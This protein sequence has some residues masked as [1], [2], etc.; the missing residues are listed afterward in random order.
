MAP[1]LVHTPKAAWISPQGDVHTIPQGGT[2]LRWIAANA[3]SIPAEHQGMGS[4]GQ[5]ATS[6]TRVGWIRKADADAYDIGRVSDLG[7]VF[8]HVAEYHPGVSEMRVQM[9][10]KPHEVG[11]KYPTVKFSRDEDGRWGR[12]MFEN[13]DQLIA[14]TL[15]ATALHAMARKAKESPHEGERDAFG[16]K[17]KQLGHDPDEILARGQPGNA[18]RYST[19]PPSSGGGYGYS[20]GPDG[21]RRKGR[22]RRPHSPETPEWAWAGWSGGIPPNHTIHSNDYHDVNFIKKDMY[23]KAEGKRRSTFSIEQFDGSYWRHSTSVKSHE[24][25][26]PHMAEAMLKWGSGANPYH[27]KAIFMRKKGSN[28]H[29]LI[30]ANGQH[31]PHGKHV[32]SHHGPRSDHRFNEK[33]SS[34]IDERVP[35]RAR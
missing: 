4:L 31:V 24:S 29:H 13:A 2:H 34:W 26:H 27:T 7:R 11:G 5:R 21:R 19:P 25:V 22:S 12:K 9:R 15:S 18:P 8:S 30:W 35:P 28:E 17:L 10:H 23:E 16:A 6:M 3:L 14:E 33:L 20:A 32:F 1:P